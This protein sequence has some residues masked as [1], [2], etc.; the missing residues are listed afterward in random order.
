MYIG[1]FAKGIGIG[2]A[3]GAAAAVTAALPL[4]RHRRR[5]PVSRALKAAGAVMS[6]LADT[7]SF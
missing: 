1:D 4:R 5:T 6:G 7:V 3:I 2:A